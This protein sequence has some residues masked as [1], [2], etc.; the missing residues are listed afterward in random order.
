MWLYWN[1]DSFIFLFFFI[2]RFESTRWCE[3]CYHFLLNANMLMFGCVSFFIL[4]LK[5][6]LCEYFREFSMYV[7]ILFL[8]FR[9]FLMWMNQG[10]TRALSFHVFPLVFHDGVLVI[11]GVIQTNHYFFS[12]RTEETLKKLLTYL[13]C[14]NIWSENFLF[15]RKTFFPGK[16]WVLF[17]I[18][19]F[20]KI[21]YQLSRFRP[22]V[23]P[24]RIKMN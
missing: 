23:M 11:R 2:W 5:H 20:S 19:L 18:T 15:Y 16:R 3:F 24:H 1:R 6:F 12:T 10:K 14:D 17:I 9:F 8:V 22:K 13:L 7:N 4:L 21:A